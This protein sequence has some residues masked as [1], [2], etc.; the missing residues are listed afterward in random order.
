[1]TEYIQSEL[2]RQRD[3]REAINTASLGDHCTIGERNAQ[4]LPFYQY[5]EN[6][7]ILYHHENYDGSGPFGLIGD[8][9]PLFAQI[10]HVADIVDVFLNLGQMDDGKFE[11]MQRF[12]K[13]QSGAMF[14][15][16]LAHLFLETIG[17]SE[18]NNIRG[19]TIDA[20]LQVAIPQSIREYSDQDMARFAS[21][22][23][24]ITDYK[25]H[26]TATHSQGVA[27]KS[28]EMAQYYGYDDATVAKVFVA[29]ALHD[30]GKLLINRDILEKPGKLSAEEYQHIKDHARFSY[31]I[32]SHIDG[33]EEITP[34]ACYHHELLDGSGYP[35]GKHAEDLNRIERTITCVDIY[36]AL[37]EDRPYRAGMNHADSVRV[38][39]QMATAGK[40]DGDIV[41]DVNRHFGIQASKRA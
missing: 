6:G 29:G 23:A 12:L 3:P 5:V 22:F 33:L 35:F 7:T 32:L 28:R 16:A 11:K 2:R 15:P 17:E 40:I 9:A 30:I 21:M 41:E 14:T 39:R 27:L 36:Q 20:T 34:W 24:R 31:D 4:I 26:F 10:I 13:N 37:T 38:L 8:S 25:S 18:L 1:L 19:D